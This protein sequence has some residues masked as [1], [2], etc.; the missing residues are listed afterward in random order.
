MGREDEVLCKQALINEYLMNIKGLGYEGEILAKEAGLQDPR[1]HETTKG[2]IKEA[3]RVADIKDRR[4][5]MENS[6]KVGDRMSDNTDHREYMKVLSLAEARVWMRVRARG[7]KG[8]KINCKSSFADLS[9]R[10]CGSEAQESQE[11]LE[12]CMATDHE[13]RGLDMSTNVGLL[14]FW[15]R[16]S[17]K[18]NK[19]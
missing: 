10:H 9:C 15:R 14:A 18:L 11:H 13:R 12:V 16:M 7:I 17:V 3:T 2:S 8:V 5:E 6:K 19:A 4:E 1:F